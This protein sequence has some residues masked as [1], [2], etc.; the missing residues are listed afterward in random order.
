M[1]V[2]AQGSPRAGRHGALSRDSAWA[3][4]SL[5]ASGVMGRRGS[6][7]LVAWNLTPGQALGGLAP[8]GL[9]RGAR[10]SA[11]LRGH[12]GMAQATH[13]SPTVLPYLVNIHVAGTPLASEGWRGWRGQTPLRPGKPWRGRGVREGRLRP[14][15][16]RRAS[17]PG[18]PESCMLAAA[19]FKGSLESGLAL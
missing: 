16:G 18:R 19:V 1:R 2:R 14:R 11:R 7:Y 12:W 8:P 17:W 4:V 13:T 15:R 3:A 10:K 5:G 6:S 9:G